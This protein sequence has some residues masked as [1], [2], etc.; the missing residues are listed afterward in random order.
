MKRKSV[1]MSVAMIAVLAV[2]GCGNAVQQ[3]Q[4]AVAATEA[5]AHESETPAVSEAETHLQAAKDALSNGDYQLALD[6]VEEALSIE[7]DNEECET[8]KSN[9]LRQYLDSCIEKEDIDEAKSIISS[10]QEKASGFDFAAYEDK[11][12]ELEEKLNYGREFMEKVYQ[13]MSAKDFVAMMDVDGTDEANAILDGMESDALIY[14][15]DQLGQHFTGEGVGIYR[16]R[17]T[18]DERGAYYFYYGNYEDGKREGDGYWFWKTGDGYEVIEMECADDVPNGNFTDTTRMKD[19]T[20]IEMTKGTL[21]NGLLDGD[22][23][24]RITDTDYGVFTAVF[25]VDDG[26]PEDIYDTLNPAQFEDWDWVQEQH[27]K[28]MIIYKCAWTADGARH[29]VYSHDPRYLM[30]LGEYTFEKNRAAYEEDRAN[31]EN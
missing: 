7:P 8:E 6:E 26:I 27:D 4:E 23:E 25:H 15:P 1:L 29:W 14:Q 20:E 28:G 11:I 9:I 13:L 12:A 17:L 10:Y 30:G 22:M 5:S 2:A 19:G 31:A 18:D 16:Y 21:K 3:P 24:Y